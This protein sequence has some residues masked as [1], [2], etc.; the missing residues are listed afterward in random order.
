MRRNTNARINAGSMADIAFLMLIFFIISTTL[1]TDQGLLRKLPPDAEAEPTNSKKRNT[2]LV[3]I[4]SNNELFIGDKKSDISQLRQAAKIFIENPH[5]LPDLPEKEFRDVPM[6]G[7]ACLTPYHVISLQNDCGTKY[8]AY[9]AVQN[10]LTAAYNEL[11]EKASLK[12]F[13]LHYESLDEEKKSAINTIFP[14]RISEA[15]PVE[16]AI[17]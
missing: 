1:D 2:L 11:R 15:N 13:N 3:L 4:N 7:Q 8:A 5:N 14:L 12:Y 10:E 9:V 16:I 6:F 17:K